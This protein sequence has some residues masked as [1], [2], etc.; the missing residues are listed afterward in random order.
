M[1]IISGGGMKMGHLNYR[2]HPRIYKKNTL[3][4]PER[5]L[6]LSVGTAIGIVAFAFINGLGLGYMLKKKMS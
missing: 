5:F 4:V 2:K 3:E 6:N 1:K